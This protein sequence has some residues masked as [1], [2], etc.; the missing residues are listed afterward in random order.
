[1]IAD[2]GFHYTSLESALSILESMTLR[3]SNIRACNDGNEFLDGV[4]VYRELAGDREG[5]ST[6]N[7]IENS[8]IPFWVSCFSRKGDDFS[9]WWLYGDSGSGACIEFDLEIL[10]AVTS[11]RFGENSTSIQQ[12]EYEPESQLAALKPH[13]DEMGAK[14]MCH[15]FNDYCR[16]KQKAFNSEQEIRLLVFQKGYPEGFK[17]SGEKRRPRFRVSGNRI[18]PFIE[19][20]FPTECVKSVRLG[21][22]ANFPRNRT[23]FDQF[24]ENY[25]FSF[26]T[27]ESAIRP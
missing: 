23:H 12:V 13:V 14:Q 26:E 11:Q 3:L 25:G 20:E 5:I 22:S 24:L 17:F 1:M 19:T 15:P 27:C 16:L 6:F 2:S 18:V 4:S 21:P 9:Q 10:A 7:G 8:S